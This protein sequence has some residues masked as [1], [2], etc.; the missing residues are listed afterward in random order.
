M[1]RTLNLT[2]SVPLT[3]CLWL[4]CG[5]VSAQQLIPLD[6]EG[7]STITAYLP[8]KGKATCTAVLVIPGGAYAF[9]ATETEGTP[10]AK[11]FAER[12]IAAFVLRYRLPAE[13]KTGYKSIGPLQ[14]GQQAL[15]LIRQ[16][17]AEFGVNPAKVGVIGFSAGGHLAATLAAKFNKPVIENKEDVNLRPDFAVLVYPVI[18]MT[19]DLTH[20]GS[21]NSL[22]GSNPT[23][24]LVNV[25]SAEQL[26]TI[27][28]PPMYITHTADDGLV[29]VQNS[30]AMYEALIAKSVDAELHLYPRGD[31]GFIQRL[32]VAE[33]LDPILLF[34]KKQGFN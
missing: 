1:K 8:E 24:S 14:D 29:K 9:L 25:F 34:M 21:R 6:G 20:M 7:G 12:G 4:L 33:W 32:P 26:V 15:K 31:H 10:I 28:T 5:I 22:L 2:L 23:D 3:F 17:A 13:I 16:R 30:L 27:N 18:S 19:K 11:A